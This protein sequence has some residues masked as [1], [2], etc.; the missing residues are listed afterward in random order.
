MIVFRYSKTN[1]AEF[2]SH[3]DTLR[4][5]NKTFIRGGIE[6]KLS[7]G[8]HPHMLVY[9]SSPI[10]VGLKSYA[11]FCTVDTD[12]LPDS[13]VEKFNSASPK[14]IKCLE[15]RYSPKNVNL[16]AAIMSARYY[17]EGIEKFCV[18]DVLNANEFLIA[19]KKGEEK[20]VREKIYSLRER[21]DGLEAVL[22][23]G[24]EVLRPD[25]FAGKLKEIY[26]GGH[27][28]IVKEEA[29]AADGAEVWELISKE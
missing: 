17:I 10:G 5:L 28:K 16:A 26:G 4:H 19:N 15:A 8:Y 18:E 12:E 3:L 27:L 7:N 21:D 11:E 2:I 23:A 14:G 22:A 9:M 6:V 20:N 29:F 25:L 1:G 13:F 24:N